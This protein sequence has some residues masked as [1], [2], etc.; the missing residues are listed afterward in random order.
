MSAGSGTGVSR[1]VLVSE[2]ARGR[3]SGASGTG[4]GV[5]DEDGVSDVCVVLRRLSSRQSARMSCS[6]FCA[7]FGGEIG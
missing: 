4:V 3:L 6:C 1:E 7:G 5:E 2:P